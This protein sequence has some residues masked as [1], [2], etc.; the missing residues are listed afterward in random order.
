M[1]VLKGQGAS[2]EEIRLKGEI[3]MLRFECEKCKFTKAVIVM[4]LE[5]DLLVE[6]LSC[7]N[8]EPITNWEY[9]DEE[10]KVFALISDN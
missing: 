8:Y 10:E 5:G 1:E 6:C 2:L 7:G 4:N 9:V 3:R